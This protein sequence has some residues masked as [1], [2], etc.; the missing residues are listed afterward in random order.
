MNC[1]IQDTD[2]VNKDQEL[3]NS[4]KGRAFHQAYKWKYFKN[5]LMLYKG[6]NV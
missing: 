2:K 3:M 4:E 6:K 1:R 5:S